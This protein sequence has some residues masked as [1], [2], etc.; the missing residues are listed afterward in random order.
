M[1][2]LVPISLRGV[3]LDSKRLD[4]VSEVRPHS[5]H[6]SAAGGG[7]TRLSSAIVAA[8]VLAETGERYP[9]CR[10]TDEEHMLGDA[11]RARVPAR[12]LR[13][14]MPAADLHMLESGCTQG[15]WICPRLDA[16]RRAYG[17]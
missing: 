10:C 16:V 7:R 17:Q 11:S 3:V 12:V 13:E 8:A 1:S 2:T 5:I 4:A 15:S 14:G 9:T 6:S